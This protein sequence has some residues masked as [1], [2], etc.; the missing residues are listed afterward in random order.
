MNLRGHYNHKGQMLYMINIV[1][2]QT[3]EQKIKQDTY[4]NYLQTTIF[5]SF[6]I[7][8]KENNNKCLS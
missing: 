1:S 7:C 5:F 3:T 4:A 8:Q 6:A 2:I